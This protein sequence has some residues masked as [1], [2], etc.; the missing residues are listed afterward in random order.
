MTQAIPFGVKYCRIV[1]LV[2]AAIFVVMGV[3]LAAIAV[4]N[5]IQAAQKAGKSP[6][7]VLTVIVALPFFAI[8]ALPAWGLLALNRGL[9]M[10]SQRAK[11]WQAVLSLI[12]L[13]GFPVG[14]LLHAGVLYFLFLDEETKA[15]FTKTGPAQ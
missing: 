1:N 4:P 10:L 14:T 9:S 6:N 11:A 2:T 15:V 3:L 12:F 5:F 8:G 13:L 7:P